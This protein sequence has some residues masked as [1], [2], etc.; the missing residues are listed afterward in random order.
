MSLFSDNNHSLFVIQTMHHSWTRIISWFR[1]K[2]LGQLCVKLTN[3][4]LRWLFVQEVNYE[5]V[6]LT[7]LVVWL[8]KDT[9][10]W[11]NRHQ[12]NQR[13]CETAPGRAKVQVYENFHS[14]YLG[15]ES[16]CLNFHLCVERTHI[17]LCRSF[18]TLYLILKKVCIVIHGNI[19]L[20]KCICS[21]HI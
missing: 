11:R 16:V 6:F 3:I 12:M 1:V 15:N 10:L 21:S 9:P 19:S 2:C 20:K 8:T 5:N 7:H 13:L 17:L 14:P 18:W 4:S